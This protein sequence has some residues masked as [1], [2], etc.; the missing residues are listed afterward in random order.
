MR[1]VDDAG[2]FWRWWSMRLLALL[3]VLTTAWAAI[4]DET[5]AMLPEWVPPLVQLVIVLGT[6]WARVYKQKDMG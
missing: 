4:P 3:G 2:N 5:K 1:L 6:M